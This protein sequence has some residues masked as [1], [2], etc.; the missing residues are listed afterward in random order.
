MILEQLKKDRNIIK[1]FDIVR[2]VDRHRSDDN[3]RLDESRAPAVGIFF[4]YENQLF[5]DDLPTAEAQPY[6]GTFK[7][8]NS[9]HMS[10]WRNLKRAGLVD[11][12]MEYD[13][14]PRGRVVYVIPDDR[15]YIWLDKCIKKEKIIDQ[16]VKEFNIPLKKYTVG[17]DAHYKCPSCMPKGRLEDW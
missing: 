6:A 15:Y 3:S 11:Q 16:I 14:I 8:G 13:Q 9:E 1:D 5:I 7:N 2:L 4:W 12:H 10:F 17:E